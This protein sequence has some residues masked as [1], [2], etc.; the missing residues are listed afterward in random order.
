MF[1]HRS[2]VCSIEGLGSVLLQVLKVLG[3]AL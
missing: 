1:Y 3:L 2:W